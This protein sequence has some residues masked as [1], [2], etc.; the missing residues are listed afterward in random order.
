[1][2]FVAESRLRAATSSRA[3]S[4]QGPLGKGANAAVAACLPLT[5]LTLLADVPLASASPLSDSLPP[6]PQAPSTKTIPATIAIQRIPIPLSRHRTGAPCDLIRAT[7]AARRT[8]DE[9][10]SRPSWHRCIPVARSSLHGAS[11]R[12]ISAH[13][14]NSGYR[15]N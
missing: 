2:V 8:A 14:L 13:C 5:G 15:P 6:P 11:Q 7:G 12:A 3:S 10:V 9:R 4:D 1:M